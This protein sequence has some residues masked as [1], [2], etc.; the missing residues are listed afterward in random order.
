MDFKNIQNISDVMS[1]KFKHST[2][3][4]E[5]TICMNSLNLI[6]KQYI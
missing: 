3:L 2:S 5:N 1:D 4:I 6:L